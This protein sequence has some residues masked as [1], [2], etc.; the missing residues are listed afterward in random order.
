M[1]SR[2]WFSRRW[3]SWK[4]VWALFALEFIF[5][6]PALALFA[7]AQPN[8]YRTRLWKDGF[9]NGFN[10]NPLGPIYAMVNGEKFDTPVVW[11]QLYVH[12]FDFPWC[13]RWVSSAWHQF[14]RMKWDGSHGFL[15]PNETA[16]MAA[17][18]FKR[19]ADPNLDSVTDYN[20]IISVLSMFL[21]L[22]KGVM[23]LMHLFRPVLGVFIHGGLAAVWAYSLYAQ[24][25]PDNSDPRFPRLSGP[26]YIVKGC[27]VAK[28]KNL[29]QYCQQAKAQLAVTV[30]MLYVPISSSPLPAISL[31]QDHSALFA[32]N[33]VLAVLSS[34]PTK[35]ERLAYR[36][37]VESNDASMQMKFDAPPT[38]TKSRTWSKHESKHNAD[39]KHAT[40]TTGREDVDGNGYE[41]R[42]FSSHSQYQPPTPGTAA[43]LL[44][45]A[46]APTP[47]TQAFQRLGGMGSGN[48]D[49]SGRGRDL[50]L[51]SQ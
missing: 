10:S 26:W 14:V 29:V 33:F 45:P 31:T 47:R 44:T 32:A 19:R 36:T 28:D 42:Y 8:L 20:V 40:S 3:R 35:S 21:L 37:S 16:I 30:V 50:P 34:I 39:D 7:I 25:S 2:L 41:S 51:R 38:T 15:R 27:G 9:D 43:A 5:T 12:P 24:T 4:A 13:S 6:I 49:A 18:M 48:G 22:V 17:G 11:R 1:A 46:G 23:F